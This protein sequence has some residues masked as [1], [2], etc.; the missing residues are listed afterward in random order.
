MFAA[1]LVNYNIAVDSIWISLT[2]RFSLGFCL[3]P[4]GRPG[5]LSPA[6]FLSALK[7]YL[8]PTELADFEA[9]T[10]AAKSVVDQ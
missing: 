6:S 3:V 1:E 7:L 9:A 2:R 5:C 10:F 4:C 8:A